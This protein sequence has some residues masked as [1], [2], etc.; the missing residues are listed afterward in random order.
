MNWSEQV[1][2]ERG[3]FYAECQDFAQSA[4]GDK[5]LALWSFME[6]I[7]W[8]IFPDF[9]LFPLVLLAPEKATRRIVIAMTTS[10]LGAIVMVL[11]LVTVP[12]EVT[13]L[14]FKL[15]FTHQAMLLKIDALAQSYSHWSVLFQPFSGIPAK[16]WL[17]DA[18]Y[19]HQWEMTAFL[20]WLGMAR[21]LRMI[22][23]GSIAYWIGTRN[24]NI[25]KKSWPGWFSLYAVAA[26]LLIAW[27]SQMA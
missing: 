3:T 25:I 26:L 5:L 19:I 12:L 14:I 2:T 1:M 16:V 27:T 18:V 20:V 15:P 10:I 13:N 6:A 7:V 17:W 23:I 8:F 24:F 9:L 4:K 22:L 21:S 11:L